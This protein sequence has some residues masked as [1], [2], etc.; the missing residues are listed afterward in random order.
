MNR[1][2]SIL[3]YP[4][5]RQLV[6]LQHQLTN[7]NGFD[8]YEEVHPPNM[9]VDKNFSLRIEYVIE[10]IHLFYEWSVMYLDN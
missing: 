7:Q 9:S 4:L 2:L 10:S 1:E 5:T 6:F 8:C 3:L